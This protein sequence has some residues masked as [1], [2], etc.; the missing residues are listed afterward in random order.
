[1]SAGTY[2][3]SPINLKTQ[4]NIDN[5]ISNE[6]SG[7]LVD[8]LSTLADTTAAAN[9]IG[10]IVHV[11]AED[12]KWTVNSAG[13]WEVL[14]G[15]GGTDDQT[16]A[17]VSYTNNGQTT[18]A[19]GLDSLF[20]R[21][22]GIDTLSTLADTA[23][24]N[25]GIGQLVYVNSVDQYWYKQKDG[26]FY[27]LET[28]G[29]TI[30]SINYNSSLTKQYAY[31]TF[32]GDSVFYKTSFFTS[33]DTSAIVFDT[34][35]N[36]NRIVDVVLTATGANGRQY[37]NTS[38]LDISWNRNIPNQELSITNNITQELDSLW[39]T[40]F[41]TS[42]YRT[43]QESQNL[44]LDEY[45]NALMAI[46]MF[47][48]RKDYTG[49]LA[50]IILRSDAMTTGDIMPDS[51][52]K[53]SESSIVAN[54][55][56]AGPNITVADFSVSDTLHIIEFYDQTGNG[57]NLTTVSQS[58]PSV[59]SRNP[60]LAMDGVVVRDS[61]NNPSLWAYSSFT[62]PK[63]NFLELSD[64]INTGNFTAYFYGQPDYS[65]TSQSSSDHMFNLGRNLT[66]SSTSHIDITVIGR[67]FDN[68]RISYGN[69][70]SFVNTVYN[71]LTI[72][73]NPMVISIRTKEDT[74]FSV[75]NQRDPKSFATGLVPTWGTDTLMIWGTGEGEL[76]S[77]SNLMSGFVIYN[78]ELDSTEWIGHK[79]FLN[80]YYTY[81][82]VSNPITYETQLPTYK[83][84]QIDL[85]NY[86]GT[87]DS[88]DFTVPQSGST[89]IS[90]SYTVGLTVDDLYP[91][92]ILSTARNARPD[93][94]RYP[95]SAF[96]LND[97]NGEGIEGK[98]GGVRVLR[99]ISGDEGANAEASSILQLKNA[100]ITNP[101]Y[102]NANAKRRLATQ[103]IASIMWME[104]K[105]WQVSNITFPEFYGM[106]LMQ[107]WLAWESS[108]SVVPD[109]LYDN[110]YNLSLRALQRWNDLGGPRDN[111]TNMDAKLWPGLAALWK[112]AKEDGYDIIADSVLTYSKR[113]ALG[114]NVEDASLAQGDSITGVI[115]HS[116][117]YIGEFNQPETSYNGL[118][119]YYMSKA[120]G[121][122]RDSV[123]WE[124]LWDEEGIVDRMAKFKAFQIF[125]EPNNIFN[126]PSGYACR[127]NAPYALDQSHSLGR[128]MLVADLS[129][130]GIQSYGKRLQTAFSKISG[131]DTLSLET[132]NTTVSSN[133]SSNYG[134]GL[135][136]KSPASYKTL[137]TPST[138][139][140]PERYDMIAYEYIKDGF[141]DNK[142]AP[143][144]IANDTSL[145]GLPCEQDTSWNVTFLGRDSV[146]EFWYYQ[147]FDST[148]TKFAGFIESWNK[149]TLNQTLGYSSIRVGGTIQTFWTPQTGMVINTRG[150]KHD[151]PNTSWDSV[152]VWAT[153]HIWGYASSDSI[154]FSSAQRD[155]RFSNYTYD[156]NIF[157]GRMTATD[158]I[159]YRINNGIYEGWN[160]TVLYTRQID[161]LKY[162][163]K[164]TTTFTSNEQ[165]S[166]FSL[167]ESVPLYAGFSTIET[168]VEYWDGI[169]WKPFPVS[170]TINTQTIRISRNSN[171]I[172]INFVQNMPIYLSPVKQSDYQMTDY[173]QQLN[174]DLHP[175]KGNLMPIASSSVEYS[176]LTQS[177][178]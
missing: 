176:I 174:I 99:S 100:G 109:S 115:F 85:Y 71:A 19:G 12:A 88:S 59:R 175:A 155:R 36:C 26:F 157:P 58:G 145:L 154:E 124:W 2:A 173:F 42:D 149:N 23:T 178:I 25:T 127:T 34:I 15:L 132:A 91:L 95:S 94:F 40:T 116:S 1:M 28:G 177:P 68:V 114:N 18:V 113:W 171:H 22:V 73:N 137:T 61:F 148:G 146:P 106:F 77:P 141:Y 79:Q 139:W 142:I 83:Q 41:Y 20:N 52:G 135:L 66:A 134:Q 72:E 86:L 104:D 78:R 120:A 126:G 70:I 31:Q 48:M 82:T 9:N 75:V 4:T 110:Y 30:N 162:G 17:E 5:Y 80:N 169:S 103:S 96:V 151:F 76:Y 112:S 13:A 125:K 161:T 159:D 147:S 138:R 81:D 130:W 165:D 105:A 158:T 50:K 6:L 93:L 128:D 118:S 156:N 111:N 10:R 97:N 152:A 121:I 69:G 49:P 37:A 33:V 45:P 123:G 122:V 64:I 11:I 90:Y 98:P 62:N 60:I 47:Q 27:P 3:Q 35:L 101:Y 102:N 74:I 168:T 129:R 32:E 117:G 166:L 16:A 131:F 54:R 24:A 119:M 84:D 8:T 53:I 44:L 172:Y 57:N 136:D 108:R 107:Q 87:L 56:D 39:V 67:Q 143:A 29:E 163:F 21:S 164:I 51:L 140:W 92:S 144:I 153:H 38:L 170:Q 43:A 133:I 46:G 89:E 55:S 14:S 150:S 7:R 63:F 167:F 65:V 160:G